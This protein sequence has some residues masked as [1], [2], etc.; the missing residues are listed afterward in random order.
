M[1]KSTS[2]LP[3]VHR[4]CVFSTQKKREMPLPSYNSVVVV[5]VVSVVDDDYDALLVAP[6]RTKC[7][8]GYMANTQHP[9]IHTHI[10]A[11]LLL[12]KL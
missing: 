3:V 2:Y 12:L 1:L 7:I 9:T 5:V 6:V 4:I 10:V 8:Y 11:L